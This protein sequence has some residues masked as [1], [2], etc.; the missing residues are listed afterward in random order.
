M[1]T[2]AVID[3][4]EGRLPTTSID[5]IDDILREGRAFLSVIVKIE[6]LSFN[7]SNPNALRVIHL[8]INKCTLLPLT[9]PIVDKTI[10]LRK[11]YNRKLPDTIIAATAFTH[12]LDL[13]TRNESDFIRMIGLTIINPHTM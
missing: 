1:D 5:E 2:N 13:M 7:P 12:N 9:D 3:Y 6:L 8:F 4:L 11:L 10:E